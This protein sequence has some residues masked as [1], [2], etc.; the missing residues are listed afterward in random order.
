MKRK[1]LLIE[2]KWKVGKPNFFKQ[3]EECIHEGISTTVP[4]RHSKTLTEMID[5]QIAAPGIRFLQEN[6]PGVDLLEYPSEEEYKYILSTNNYDIVG[7]SFRTYQI[8]DAIKMA[9]IA[10]KYKV[11]KVIAG[12]WGTMSPGIKE[13]FDYVIVGA[14][15]NPMRELLGYK[16]LINFKHPIFISEGKFGFFKI[17]IGFLF[18]ARGCNRGCKYCL[19]PRFIS[20]RIITPK[21]EIQRVLDKYYEEGVNA[22]IIYD[23]N[24]PLN[25]EIG[26][27]TINLLAE[28]GLLWFCLVRLDDLIGKVKELKKAGFIGTLTGIE[29]LR[30]INLKDWKKGENVNQILCA[31]KEI[32][33]NDCYIL[34]TYIFCAEN[35]TVRSMKKDI[36]QL[37]NL[38]V[39]VVMPCILTP[40]PGTPLFEKLLHE[41][42]IIDWNWL[43]WDDGHLVWKHS[44]ITPKQAKNIVFECAEVCNNLTRIIVS[45]LKIIIGP[46]MY[47]SLLRRIK[48]NLLRRRLK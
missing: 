7:I 33:N 23:D 48:F 4:I 24:F 12:G 18:T 29:S 37:K 25:E 26:Q 3:T 43:H 45:W 30:N 8:Y 32:K 40:Y 22:V 20:K 42:K 1:I 6:V 36:Q 34:G 39:P 11:S 35:D 9:K 5:L 28:R 16:P 44:H 10:R 15:E 47:H 21:R 27:A 31:I 41:N 17:K 19:S 38:K 46:R 14:G 2:S 13:Y